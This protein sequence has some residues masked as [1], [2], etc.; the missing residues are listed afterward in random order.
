MSEDLGQRVLAFLHRARTATASEI[1]GSL[2]VDR[3]EVN[4]VLYQGIGR[5]YCRSGDQP[6]RWSPIQFQRSQSAFTPGHSIPAISHHDFHIDFAG[7]DWKLRIVVDDASRN[8]PI[9]RVEALGERHRLITVA[10]HAS[11]QMNG[12]IL[13]PA[14][15]GIASSM[16]AWE[17]HQSLRERGIEAFHF[18]EAVRDIFLSLSWQAANL[19][20]SA[21]F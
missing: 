2:G 20:E 16:L 8:D 10:T 6:P 3:R 13:P 7:G 12:P 9:A 19:Q 17:I 5:S 14:A 4:S 1:A 11:G 15:I 21:D 18:G